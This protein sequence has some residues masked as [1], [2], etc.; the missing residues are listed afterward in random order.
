MSKEKGISLHV[1]FNVLS[2]LLVVLTALS[3]ALFE[4]NEKQKNGLETLIQ[5]G[6]E[7]SV[8]IS[9]L[10]EYAMFSEDLASLENIITHQDPQI[11]YLA[12]LRPDM[13]IL[14]E[15]NFQ[16]INLGPFL[17]K[18]QSRYTSTSKKSVIQKMDY[19]D[20]GDQLQFVNPII[21]KM[22]A[23][24][25]SSFPGED[26]Q[27]EHDEILGY[28]HLILNKKQMDFRVRKSIYRI[29]WVTFL[30][31]I[32]AILI[33]IFVTYQIIS[34]IKQLVA[35]TQNVA[36]GRLV[37]LQIDA[38]WEIGFLTESFNKMIERLIV[39][40]QEIKTYQDSLEKKVDERTIDLLV[41]KQEAESSS[42]AKSEFLA[43]MS[44]E[45]R[46]PMNAIVGMTELVL[47]TELNDRQR[48]F[49][50]TIQSSN[51]A[52]LEII[53]DILDFSK[54][55]AGKLQLKN[56][57]FNLQEMVEDIADLLAS[58]A[59]LKNLEMV[60]VIPLDLPEIV[61]GDPIRIRQILINLLG[62]AIKFTEKGEVILRVES[63]AQDSDTI[64]LLFC[65]DDS[66][67]GIP[68]DEQENIFN[69]FSQADG[70]TT[71]NYG[72]TGLGLAICRQLVK[73][74]GGEIGVDSK[75][76]EGST[77]WFIVTLP[78]IASAALPADPGKYLDGY[79]ILIVDD[80]RTNQRILYNQVTSWGMRAD[81]AD[82]GTQAIEMLH[83]QRHQPYDIALLDW[84]MPGM[85][86]VELARHI[87]TDKAIENIHLVLLSSAAYDNEAV[88]TMEQCVDR[89]LIKPVR[90]M[91][92]LN[93]LTQ[94]TNS[95]NLATE[96]QEKEKIKDPN[97][98]HAF[99]S[100]ILLVE[101][102]TTNQLVA[103]E[104]LKRMGCEVDIVENG[105]EA[106]DAV[107]EREYDLILMDCQMPVMDGFEATMEI[108]LH[109]REEN[110]GSRIP[111]IA[112]TG[113]VIQGV[114]E[115]CQEA[116]MDDYLSKPFTI[117]ELREK[118][119]RWIEPVATTELK[120]LQ[121]KLV[122]QITQ[123]KK[124]KQ[125]E[126]NDLPLL[127]PSKISLLHDLQIEGEPSF[128]R[129][130]VSNYLAD[131]EPLMALLTDI[132]ES[133]DLEKLQRIAHTLK[134]S[135]GNVGAMI[136]S[137]L[138]KDL[139]SN[140]KNRDLANIK[141][142]INRIKKEFVRAKDALNQ[143]ILKT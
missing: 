36:E 51:S 141:E 84:K 74:M 67:I 118:L 50:E 102:N 125:A 4:I 55:E 47:E 117:S 54:I 133:G 123:E 9:D 56:Y 29:L 7:K 119:S 134:S 46:T 16:Q 13:S 120:V 59:H 111:I 27:I 19:T 99:A 52:L 15:Q 76:G 43:T 72:G 58:R 90:Q 142:I 85:D 33:T 2:V 26:I 73:L 80:N 136:V 124:S 89:Y 87:R 62:N 116:G 132:F 6:V 41:A 66:G 128:I 45:I 114:Q 28:V 24:L 129:H 3:I 139:E 92:L 122:D 78:Y 8:F 83:A 49:V 110:V 109:E 91:L 39:A 69:A 121:G 12:L 20:W 93:C 77:F 5:Q 63:V 82:N 106:V 113:N 1:K 94:L 17:S 140:C 98:H 95:E 137:E 11:S 23:D 42:Q 71:R 68:A 101:D 64:Q 88:R 96:K 79:K 130:I 60:P 57:D 38:E 75:V 37:P 25:D 14:V 86:G 135:S 65:V 44:H 34:P 22:S 131:T 103:C 35:A 48:N 104:I 126:V 81:T 30:I 32:L 70:S 40:R 138:C 97:K 107:K 143:E 108:R 112:L 21:S 18:L 105:C 127:D 100:R 53:N 61:Q 10:S 31:V 115:Q